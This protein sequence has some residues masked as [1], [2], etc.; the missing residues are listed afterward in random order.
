ME[1]LFLETVVASWKQIINRLDQRFAS[2]NDEQL[3]RQVAPGKNRLF[4]LLGHLTVMHDRTLPLLD[5]S[6]ALYPELADAYFTNPD[7]TLTDPLPAADL[8]NA[9]YEVNSRI[10][11]AAERY[12]VEE[13]LAKHTAA[14]DEDF[15]KNPLR[16][17]LAVFLNRTNHAAF[18]TGQAI[19]SR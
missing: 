9:W 7:R 1:Q 5:I 18:H 10:T 15:S 16:N 11:A 4:Y 12:S 8:K 13:W 19:L 17:R 3:Q 6:K 14:S 2:L